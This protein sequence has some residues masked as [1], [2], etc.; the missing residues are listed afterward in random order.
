[1]V[2]AVQPDRAI[3]GSARTEHRGTLDYIRRPVARTNSPINSFFAMVQDDPSVQI[4]SRAQRDYVK[5]MLATT[6]YADLPVL[7]ATSPFKAGGRGGSN[8]FTDV[9]AG[10]IAIKNVADLY[11][12]PNTVRAVR[13]TG[14]QVREW[15][16]KSALVFNRI[17]TSVTTPQQL[18]NDV[19]PAYNFDVMGGV[20][21]RIDV[22]QPARYNA[23]G[24][25]VDM[26]AHRI[27]DLQ[28]EG[29]PIEDAAWF[30]VATNNYRAGG[31]GSFPAL[32]GSNI[33]LETSDT[34]QEILKDWLVAQKNVDTRVTPN[35]SF[36]PI[37]AP[38][39]VVFESSPAARRFLAG[40]TR[41]RDA[42]N[43][44]RGFAL[45]TIDLE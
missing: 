23:D 26:K 43:A 7:S 45:F 17:D 12:Y 39:K 21:Y 31:G 33:V 40:Q 37:S 27:V 34:N 41:I 1:M 3:E 25:I 8:Y 13:I 10:D 35:W 28:F 4:V 9:P 20:T 2:A 44:P 16:E 15:L 42:G 18:V 11:L 22:T 5:A 24:K 6:P 38:V 32:D 19:I 36:A 14:A 30:I 29:K